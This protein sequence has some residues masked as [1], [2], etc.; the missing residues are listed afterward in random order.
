MLPFSHNN[1]YVYILQAHQLIGL[2]QLPQQMFSEHLVPVPDTT[3]K[4]SKITPAGL[5]Q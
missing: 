5:A 1:V 4:F 3:N 2:K